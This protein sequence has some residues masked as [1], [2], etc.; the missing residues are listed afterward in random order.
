MQK[1]VKNQFFEDN[2]NYLT[3][4]L[5][6]KDCEKFYVAKGG[7]TISKLKEKVKFKP[8]VNLS[9]LIRTNLERHKLISNP[10]TFDVPIPEQVSRPTSGLVK[11][12]IY[13]P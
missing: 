10:I 8:A 2:D 4:L 9:E 5:S 7:D 1:E 13:F 12:K 3:N 6:Q 11:K